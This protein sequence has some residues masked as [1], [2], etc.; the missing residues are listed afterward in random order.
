MSRQGAALKANCIL[1]WIKRNMASRSPSTL[2]LQDPAWST[3]SSS[4]VLSTGKTWTLGVG[5]EEGHKNDQ[6]DGAPF[7]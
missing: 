1:G 7:L 5:P 6:R 2:L 4:R 3:A